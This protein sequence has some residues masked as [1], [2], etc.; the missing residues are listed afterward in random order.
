MQNMKK[1]LKEMLNWTSYAKISSTGSSYEPAPDL[2]T[3]I[4]LTDAQN[5]FNDMYFSRILYRISQAL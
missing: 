5:L 3:N 4:G 1:E 2:P